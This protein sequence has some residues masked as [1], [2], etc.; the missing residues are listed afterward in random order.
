MKPAVPR[1]DV[2]YSLVAEAGTQLDDLEEAFYKTIDCAQG[3]VTE[4]AVPEI[5]NQAKERESYVTEEGGYRIECVSLLDRGVWAMRFSHPDF[6]M[7]DDIPAVAGRHWTTDISVEKLENHV[8]FSIRVACAS[9]ADSPPA[10]YIRPGV[11][12]RLAEAA[13]LEQGK[14]LSTEPWTIRNPEELDELEAFLVSEERRLPIFLVTQ[15]NKFR[16]THTPTAPPYLIDG[17]WL[18]RK[19]IGYA[20]V[21]MMPFDVGYDWTR[22]VGNSWTA[23]DGAV[24]VY[25]PGLNFDEDLPRKH[26]VFFKDRIMAYKYQDQTGNRAFS[27]H[28]AEIVKPYKAN[29]LIAWQELPFVPRARTMLADLQVERINDTTSIDEMKAIYETQASALREQL[30]AAELEAEQWSDEAQEE[31][32]YRKAHE[33]ENKSLRSKVQ[34][35]TDALT[36]KSGTPVDE[37]IELPESYDEMAEW[38]SRELAGRLVLLPRAVRTL[39]DAQYEDPQLVAKSILLLANEYRDQ[40]TGRIELKEFEAAKNALHLTCKGSITQEKAGAHGDT[41][42]VRYPVGTMKKEFLKWHL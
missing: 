25:M 41:Y 16:W 18:A 3:W 13:G 17:Y 10:E 36:A 5:P 2:T 35:L 30:K 26:A 1:S 38:V 8:R 4:K 21:V 19:T 27:E 12:R 31:H 29:R 14:P 11:I 39:K 24:R 33:E 7:G 9:P 32:E 37:D 15:P 42:F 20:H 23:F 22:K 34:T 6:G 28:A 40:R